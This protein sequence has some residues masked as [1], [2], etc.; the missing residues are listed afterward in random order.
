MPSPDKTTGIFSDSSLKLLNRDRT[1]DK[2]Y[3]DVLLNV[4]GVVFHAHRF[5]LGFSS[6][7]FHRIFHGNLKEKNVCQI[8]ITG[9]LGS[10]I[11]PETMQLIIVYL[12]TEEI[13]LNNDIIYD[14][15]M[16]ADYLD[17]QQLVLV[18]ND[19]LIDSI[20][21][22]TWLNTFAIAHQFN[23]KPLIS[24]CMSHFQ[25]VY[26]DLNLED[27]NLF[28]FQQNAPDQHEKLEKYDV[29]KI[30]MSWIFQFKARLKVT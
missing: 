29:F 20:T 30:I 26:N 3:C 22:E 13:D 7:Y 24:A 25:F 21:A 11:T 2:I 16:A 18:C 23:L 27:L 1:E 28:D 6:G 12:Y 10:R 15:I 4:Q 9:P 5:L 17:M 8:E 19:Y 14:V